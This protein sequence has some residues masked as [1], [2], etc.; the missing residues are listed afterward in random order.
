MFFGRIFFSSEERRNPSEAFFSSEGNQAR[1]SSEGPSEEAYEGIFF[2]RPSEEKNIRPMV[3]SKVRVSVGGDLPNNF[4]LHA[5][6]ALKFPRFFAISLTTTLREECIGY[7]LVGMPLD[8]CHHLVKLV[9][10]GGWA[11]GGVPC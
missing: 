5:A 8:L 3:A 2:R 1:I 7:R 11:V 9:V 6:F 4:I 10:A